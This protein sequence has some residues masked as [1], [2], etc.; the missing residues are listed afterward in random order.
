MPYRRS[1]PSRHRCH[2]RGYEFDWEGNGTFSATLE[3]KCL[4]NLWNEVIFSHQLITAFN[5]KADATWSHSVLPQCTCETHFQWYLLCWHFH[6][7]WTTASILQHLQLNTTWPCKAGTIQA[8]WASGTRRSTT[9]AALEA[10]M[11]L[12]PIW[13]KTSMNSPATKTTPSPLRPGQHVYQVCFK[14]AKIQ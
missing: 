5:N 6:F 12:R 9:L 10:T 11:P 1:L 7:Q 3:I 8:A 2:E 4:V 13:G 14:G